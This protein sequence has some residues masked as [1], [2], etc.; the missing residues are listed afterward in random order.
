MT[1][2]AIYN[3]QVAAVYNAIDVSGLFQTLRFTCPSTMGR[4]P[5]DG[6]C[7]CPLRRR[8]LPVWRTAVMSRTTPVYPLRREG[9]RRSSSP[10]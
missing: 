4:D 1:Y 6:M 5:L 10:R 7:G 2:M 8:R 3:L 9:S